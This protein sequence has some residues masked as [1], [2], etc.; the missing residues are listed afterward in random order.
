MSSI[1]KIRHILPPEQECQ[2]LHF[3]KIIGALKMIFF[4][5]EN[6]QIPSFHI[7]NSQ[8]DNS[9]LKHLKNLCQASKMV[10]MSF[11]S[12]GTFKNVNTKF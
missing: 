9:K 1:P 7:N 3:L 6:L 4:L 2:S 12:G 10:S 8:K 5:L 11:A